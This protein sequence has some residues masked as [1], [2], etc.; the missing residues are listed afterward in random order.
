MTGIKNFFC[1][2]N[3]RFNRYFANN[4]INLN[5]WQQSHIQRNTTVIFHSAFLHTA[6]KHL[7]HGNT[8]NTDI[9]QCKFQFFKFRLF[10]YNSDFGHFDITCKRCVFCNTL[11][12]DRLDRSNRIGIIIGIILMLGIP[13]VISSVYDV[14]PE[15]AA[16]VIT[17]GS[18]LLA[19]FIPT[20]IAEVFSYTPILGSSAY[21]TFL[22]GNVMNLKVPVVVNAQIMSDTASGT[23]EGDAVATIG[24]AVSS[25]VTTLIIAGGV[26]LLVPL[27]PILT[28]PTVQTATTYLLPALFGGI[29]LSFVNNDCGDYVAKGKPLTMILPLL[30]VFGVNA[31]F[32]LAGMEG[33]VVLI[34]MVLTVL[35]A[36]VLYKA[37]IIKMT[38]KEKKKKA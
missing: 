15:S 3:D 26:L 36:V 30:V 6:S 7:C 37:G 34:C 12:R 28:S 4:D 1:C 5:F 10:G 18:G 35:C 20:C 19:V 32:P 33:F 17:A 38:P 22:T 24:V 11:Y 16:Q 2:L 31:V 25:I 9:V 14:W 21:I 8:R 27:R 13:A 23:E 29:F